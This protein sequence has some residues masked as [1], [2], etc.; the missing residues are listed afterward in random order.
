[1][2]LNQLLQPILKVA[3]IINCL[4][5]LPLTPPKATPRKRKFPLCFILDKSRIV[6]L[7]PGLLVWTIREVLSKFSVP[8]RYVAGGELAQKNWGDGDVLD[9]GEA[10]YV[11]D[12]CERGGEDLGFVGVGEVV[13]LCFTAEIKGFVFI[14]VP[15][16]EMNLELID[17]RR[18]V[19]AT[20]IR[21][22]SCLLHAKHGRCK[23]GDTFLLQYPTGL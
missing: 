8:G 18:N 16:F 6:N 2:R 14:Q 10:H 13:C 11:V 4:Y 9:A 5:N 1:M 19:R 7:L 20:R 17:I 15:Q 23:S 3:E 12:G 21:C 22:Q